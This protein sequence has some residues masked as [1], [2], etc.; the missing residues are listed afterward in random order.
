MSKTYVGDIGTVIVLDCGQDVSTASARTIEVKKPDQTT[1]SWTAVAEGTNSIKFTTV[2]GT[3][4]QPGEW[5]LQ[6]KVTI[7][8]GVWRGETARLMVYTT[9][10]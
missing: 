8:S 3:L 6:A 9:F 1:V 5:L 2:S 7:G 4:D 10:S